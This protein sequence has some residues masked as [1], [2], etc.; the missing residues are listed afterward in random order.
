M[1]SQNIPSDDDL[2][3]RTTPA[4]YDSKTEKFGPGAYEL[5]RKIKEEAYSVE[6]EKFSNPE[7]ASVSKGKKYLVAGLYARIPRSQQLQVN[8]TPSLSNDAHSSIEGERLK[9]PKTE[10]EIALILAEESRPLITAN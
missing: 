3:R 4:M 8:H 2:Y 10:Y 7:K 5:R 1:E 6:W 9:D